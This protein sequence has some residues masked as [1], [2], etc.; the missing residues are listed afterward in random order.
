MFMRV[1]D[2]RTEDLARVIYMCAGAMS[3]ALRAHNVDDRRLYASRP[4]PLSYWC[5]LTRGN[6]LALARLLLDVI[7]ESDERQGNTNPRGLLR[8]RAARPAL[9]AIALFAHYIPNTGA[10]T[11]PPP[12]KI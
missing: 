8:Y 9:V 11:G 1:Q 7:T 5:Q 2:V 12:L 10:V 6:F 3:T 4:T